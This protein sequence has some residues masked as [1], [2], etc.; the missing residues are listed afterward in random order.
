MDRSTRDF[1]CRVVDI[2][3]RLE[4]QSAGLDRP[5]LASLLAIAK[6]EAEDDLRTSAAAAQALS[7]FQKNDSRARLSS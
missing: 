3:G 2:L 6:D 5:L 7:E 1:L 4:K